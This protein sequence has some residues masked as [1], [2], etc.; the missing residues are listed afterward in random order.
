MDLALPS[1]A[2][3]HGIT[4]QYT[5]FQSAI[6]LSQTPEDNGKLAALEMKDWKLSAELVVLSACESG[7]GKYSRGDGRLGF[8][9]A[10]FLAGAR[11]IILSQWQVSDAAT[12][13]LM[14]RFCENWLGERNDKSMSKAEAL[15]EARHG[16]RNLTQKE[17]EERLANQPEAARGLKLESDT[18]KPQTADD[19]P[20]A[21][22]Y[23]WSA[24]ILIGD[25]AAP[26]PP[27]QARFR[28]APHLPRRHLHS[29]TG[30]KTHGKARL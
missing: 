9:Q 26:S 19:K 6:I 13:L 10:L 3:T 16:L 28:L 12:A 23:Y 24:F 5:A 25:P 22:P 14:V 30:P 2:T 18:A 20:F 1:A 7:L 8:T 11:S 15:K 17:V 29:R 4:D 27:V 21:H